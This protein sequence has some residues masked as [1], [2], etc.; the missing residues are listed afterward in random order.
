MTELEPHTPVFHGKEFAGN[1]YTSFVGNVRKLTLHVYM[2]LCIYTTGLQ[3]LHDNATI[4]SAGSVDTFHSVS[5]P[6]RRV[7]FVP[8]HP[9]FFHSAYILL[10]SCYKVRTTL[11][12]HH[13]F[14]R[15]VL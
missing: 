1:G 7:G 13:L 11:H 9:V 4:V 6:A 3:V 8:G 15:H 12:M 14:H 10:L 5:K 2:L